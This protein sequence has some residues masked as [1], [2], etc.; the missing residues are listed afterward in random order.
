MYNYEMYTLGKSTRT[1]FKN[2]STNNAHINNNTATCNRKQRYI[3][4]A[5]LST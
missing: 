2:M 5:N 3:I 1:E 4:L